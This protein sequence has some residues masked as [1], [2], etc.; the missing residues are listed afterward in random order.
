MKM[1]TDDENKLMKRKGAAERGR[2]NENERDFSFFENPSAHFSPCCALVF[3]C[4]VVRPLIIP[5]VIILLY[6]A[7]EGIPGGIYLLYYYY[8]YGLDHLGS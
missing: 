8:I 1:K 7:A 3:F 2:R 6:G 4:L 5:Q